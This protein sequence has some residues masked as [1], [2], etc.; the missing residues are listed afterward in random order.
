MPEFPLHQGR[1]YDIEVQYRNGTIARGVGRWE[2]ETYT[3]ANGRHPIFVDTGYSLSAGPVQIRAI[4][5]M[6][7]HEGRLQADVPD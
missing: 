6:P 2:G 5:L 7:E 4:A 1:L 3:D